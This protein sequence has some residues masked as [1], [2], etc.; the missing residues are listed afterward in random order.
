[1]GLLAGGCTTGGNGGYAT[2]AEFRARTIGVE[3]APRRPGARSSPY[4]VVLA[5]T[6]VLGREGATRV[7]YAPVGRA[8]GWAEGMEQGTRR[9]VPS[10]I[11]R[12]R[13]EPLAPGAFSGALFLWL[14]RNGSEAPEIDRLGTVLATRLESEVDAIVGRARPLGPESVATALS[15]V[16][17]TVA[18]ATQ[19]L[20]FAA[21]ETELA[22]LTGQGLGTPDTIVGMNSF[23]MVNERASP[24]RFRNGPGHVSAVAGR[25]MPFREELTVEE[26]AGTGRFVVDY[27][28]EADSGALT[29]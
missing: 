16:N 9:A 29:A 19:D 5:Y 24:Q 2:S 8:R 13:L 17:I 10:A 11:G 26:H 20:V 22:R 14:D 7:S 18:G 15:R 3:R 6:S 4:P 21:A 27:E 23:H 25:L 12:V 1:M 28:I